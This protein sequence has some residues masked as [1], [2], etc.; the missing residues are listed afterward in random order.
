MKY[1]IYCK[2]LH[3]W[4]AQYFSVFLSHLMSLNQAVELNEVT[5]TALSTNVSLISDSYRGDSTLMFSLTVMWR[6]HWS[7]STSQLLH[8]HGSKVLPPPAFAFDGSR[9]IFINRINSKLFI[10]NLDSAAIQQ[11]V[12]FYFYTWSCSLIFEFLI[13]LC[14]I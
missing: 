14:L 9:S 12:F 2:H 5:L 3:M 7:S 6:N 13:D 11:W 10:W 8:M 4:L 1:R